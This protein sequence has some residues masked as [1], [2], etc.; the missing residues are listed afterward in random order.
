MKIKIQFIPLHSIHMRTATYRERAMAKSGEPR[1]KKQHSEIMFMN[2]VC[3]VSGKKSD[4][5]ARIK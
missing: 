3:H 5:H 1:E 2:I 4:K